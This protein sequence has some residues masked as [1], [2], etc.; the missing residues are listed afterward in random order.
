MDVVKLMNLV[1]TALK[2]RVERM[3]NF[4]PDVTET[5]KI[6]I[7]EIRKEPMDFLAAILFYQS[8]FTTNSVKAAFEKGKKE[9]Y[10][11]GV[12]EE[13]RHQIAMRN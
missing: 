2:C 1:D 3:Q 11:K 9:G 6:L 5:E 4:N 12:E 8:V 10:N 7:E 13:R